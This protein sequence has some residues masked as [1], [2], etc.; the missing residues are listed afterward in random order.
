[1]KIIAV[2]C[3]D[4]H[5][6]SKPNRLSIR[7]IAGHGIE[8]DAHAGRFVKHRNQARQTP[9]MLNN[10]QVHLLQ[11]EL[12]D[13]VKELGFLV[14]PGDL[15]ENITT[16]GLDLVGT[17]LHLGATAVVK[18][19]GLRTPCVYIDKFQKGLK[20]AMIVRTPGGSTFRAGVLGV[21]SAGGDVAPN[22]TIS[23]EMPMDPIKLPAI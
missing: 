7:L 12:F 14:G 18:L 21:V 17:L 11:S 19:T 10:R 8:G 9:E 20:R 3:S 2:C 23:V 16:R 1:M 4:A 13:E 15:G 5:R 6:F 22:D